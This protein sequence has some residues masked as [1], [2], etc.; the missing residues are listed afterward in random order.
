MSAP[1]RGLFDLLVQKHPATG[2]TRGLGSGEVLPVASDPTPAT[3]PDP[4]MGRYGNLAPSG[5]AL[6]AKPYT[7]QREPYD[8]RV[9]NAAH[10]LLDHPD[11]LPQP[12]NLLVP[13]YRYGMYAL[14]PPRSQ[15]GPAIEDRF[16]DNFCIAEDGMMTCRIPGA[17]IVT[18]PFPQGDL[19]ARISAADINAHQY[20]RSTDAPSLA[21]LSQ[22]VA[23]NPTPGAYDRPAAPEGTPNDAVPPNWEGA[24]GAASPVISYRMTDPQSGLDYVLNVTQRGHPLYPGVVLS[25]ARPAG[26][27][28]A[29]ID[30][31]GVGTSL[32][33]S[34][35][36]LDRDRFADYW[37]P[38]DG[39][40]TARQP[41]K[42]NDR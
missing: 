28:H 23:E 13:L 24:P 11:R 40:I 7:P 22:A 27:G 9:T 29:M 42:D 25:I 36:N 4:P 14:Q 31:Y 32:A 15:D 3:P 33:Q 5:A 6:G 26:Q 8:N 35:A 39:E 16:G 17:G 2:P 19:P 30:T 41:R 20:R 21:G 38:R 12:F 10:A 34:P 37:P 18:Q 1:P